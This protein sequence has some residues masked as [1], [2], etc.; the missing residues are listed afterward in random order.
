MTWVAG[1]HDGELSVDALLD[2]LTG[3]FDRYLKATGRPPDT[4]VLGAGARDARWSAG[5]ASATRR[6]GSPPAY[7]AAGPRRTDQPARPGRATRSRCSPRPAAAPAA[8]TNLPGDRR[9]AGAVRPASPATRSA[10]CPVSR[11]PFTTEPLADPLTLI[12]SGRVDLEVTS[13]AEPATLFV[14]LWDLG[15]D[16]ERTA[17]RADARPG[18]SSAVLPAAGRGP[19]P[20]DRAHP[21]SADAGHGR[22]AGGRPPG[23]GRPPA[24]GGGLER[25]TRRTPCP[26]QSAVYQV[27]LTGD[28]TL[29]LPQVDARP[30]WTR[31]TLD[32]PL[33]LIVVVGAAG[34]WPRS[35][36]VVWLWRRQRA[37][38]PDPDAGRR[39][40]GGRRTWSR[41]TP[42]GFRAV[43]GIS[44]RAEPGQ[45]VGLLGPNGA[46]KTTAIRMLVGL[47]RPDSGQIFVHGEPVHAGADVLGSVGA[48]IEGPGFLPHLT[49]RQNLTRVL[50]G[51]RPPAGGGPPGGGAGDRR[52]GIG[53]RSQ[54]P[55]LQPR[56]AA[57]AGHRPGDARA[58]V[59]AGA[60]RADQRARPAADQ[61]DAGGAGRLRRGRPDGG[62]LL[63]PAR[64]G[65]AH[66]LPRRGDGPGQGGAD[67]RGGRR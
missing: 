3:W 28:R 61:G 65:R 43:D 40:A 37:A 45:V 59:A 10:C 9:R 30:R 13:S 22:A 17:G 18:P 36:A 34:G 12:G 64:R 55:R 51:H 2:D 50:A 42:D 41:P 5:A 4:V 8:L 23:A 32:V 7:P 25:P 67:R 48:F 60:G 1:G 11:R 14:S 56:D 15:P 44:F 54:G 46:G 49:G 63:A 19:G 39:A 47:I 16:I 62:D 31:P 20:A 53:A 33:P 6:P 38:H 21:G 24:A 66:L 26:T 52:A 57:A 58:A 29:A 27:A 35:A